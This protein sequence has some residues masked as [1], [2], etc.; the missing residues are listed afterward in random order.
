MRTTYIKRRI[1]FTLGLICAAIGA[2]SLYAVLQ[3]KAITCPIAVVTAKQGD[4]L[5]SIAEHYCP[6]ERLRMGQLVDIMVQ[7][8]NGPDIYPGQAIFLPF[9]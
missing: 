6:N 4:S 1:M 5:S 9:K 2:V 3:E 8:N 7:M